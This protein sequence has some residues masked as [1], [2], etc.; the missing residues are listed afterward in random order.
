[1]SNNDAATVLAEMTGRPRGEFVPEEEIPDF[2]DQEVE[3]I[4]D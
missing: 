4:H 3:E 1:M 2:E